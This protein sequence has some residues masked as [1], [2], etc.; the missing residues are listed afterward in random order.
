MRVVAKYVWVLLF[1]AFVGAFLFADMSGLIGQGAVTTS[2]VVAKVNGEEIPYL[3]LENL[4]RSLAQQQEQ[5]LG[6][7]INLDERAQI[8]TQ[9]FEQLVTDVLLRQE[10]ERR[11][12][13]VTDEEIVEA[14]RFSPPPQFYSAPELQTEGRFDPDKYRRYLASPVARQQGLLLQLEQYYRTE[15]PRAKLFSQLASEAWL[16]D[17]QLWSVY[18]DERDSARVSFIALRPT[19]AQIAAVTVSDAEARA[20]YQRYAGRW[21]RPGQAVVSMVSVSRIPVA[22]DSAAV[23]A[24]IRALRAE[25]ASGRSTFQDVASR[26][27]EDSVSAVNGGD[28]GRGVRGRFVASFETPA[29]ALRTGQISEPVKSE[30]GWHLIQVTERKGDTLGLRHILLKFQQSDSTALI[31][32]RTADRLANLASSATD[33][34][35]FDDAAATL[36]LLAVQVPLTE[37]Q[38]AMYAG[39]AVGSITGW[40]FGGARVG[41]TSELFDDANGYYLVRLDSLTVGGDQPFETVREEIVQALRERK[42][43]DGLVAQGEA[44]LADARATSLE[45]AAR[46]AGLTA[47]T[48]ERGF[49]RLSFVQGLGF[50][51]EAIGAAFGVPIGQTAM[52]RTID[53]VFILRPDWRKEATR[54][55]WEEQKLAQRQTMVSA[56][57]EQRVRR[58][59]EDLRREADVV[60]RRR[61]I[62]AQLRRQVVE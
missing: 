50:S 58:F 45:A 24:R 14:S 31:S 23:L 2:T 6:R 26:E 36:G 48:T 12:I 16:S 55:A 38:P 47:D 34:Q 42:S 35:K 57:R 59:L 37:G 21:E 27:S 33:P 13:R 41:E 56:A 60:D 51:N 15:I 9:A 8:E 10:Y 18:Q 20:Y 32:D 52:V 7:S 39:R 53:A 5:Q 19:A 3:A 17:E 28:L 54:A 1:V 11:G 40:A 22:A 44:L 46:K 43:V 30:F 29:Y 61:I 62:N 25:I 49:T 4:T